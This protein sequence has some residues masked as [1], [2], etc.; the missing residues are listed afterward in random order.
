M[1]PSEHPVL[2]AIFSRRSIRR[3]TDRPVEREKICT[4]LEAAMAAP[5]A[6]NIQPWEFIVIDEPEAVRRFKEVVSEN[7]PYNAPLVIVVCG[8]AELIPWGDDNGIVDCAAAIE[9]MLI[10]A[11]EMGL[12]SVWIGGFQPTLIR[13]ELHIPEQVSVIGIAYFG[14]PDEQKE[15]RTKYLEEAV[16]WQQY[17]PQRE[18]QKRPDALA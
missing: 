9:N 8:L 13:K 16:Y 2:D 7:G 17:D 14:Y 6:C 10:A 15:P 4:L 5:S 18:H 12:G 1:T 11:T 3:Y